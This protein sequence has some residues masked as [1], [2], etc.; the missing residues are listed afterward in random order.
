MKRVCKPGGSDP[1]QEVFPSAIWPINLQ[2]WWTFQDTY[3]SVDQRLPCSPGPGPWMDESGRVADWIEGHMM[4][5]NAYAAYE[6]QRKKY[7]ERMKTWGSNPGHV[8]YQ[9]LCLPAEPICFSVINMTNKYNKIN[10]RQC[11]VFRAKFKLANHLTPRY[12]LL[13]VPE[14]QTH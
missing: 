4:I 8:L 9:Q 1:K 11:F 3:P 12:R 13:L 6:Y 5:H 10:M 7:M 2:A 14:T